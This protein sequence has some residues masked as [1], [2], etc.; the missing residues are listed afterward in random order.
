MNSNYFPF[1]NW[2]S[3]T[4]EDDISEDIFLQC[5]S[6]G[7]YSKEIVSFLVDLQVHLINLILHLSSSERDIVNKVI[8]SQWIY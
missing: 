2:F 7:L 4:T 1:I 5:I 8:G 6:Q 3:F